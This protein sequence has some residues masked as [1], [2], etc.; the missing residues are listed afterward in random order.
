MKNKS[1]IK[2]TLYIYIYTLHSIIN[3]SI[4][5][6]IEIFLLSFLI[7]LNYNYDIFIKA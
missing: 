4:L 5:V 1:L 7:Y 6:V 2:N 3:N